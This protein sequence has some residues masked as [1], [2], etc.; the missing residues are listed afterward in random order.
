MLFSPFL[1]HFLS[2]EQKV[3]AV[4]AEQGTFSPSRSYLL[5]EELCI[6]NSEG[7]PLE[8]VCSLEEPYLEI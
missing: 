5:F 6:L 8:F 1:L 7:T 2:P 3:V 4:G